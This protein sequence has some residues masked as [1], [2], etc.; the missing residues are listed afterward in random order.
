MPAL[1]RPDLRGSS[2]PAARPTS[3]PPVRRDC[4]G[5]GE[6][7]SGPRDEHPLPRRA[8]RS[9][10]GPPEA[11]RLHRRPAAGRRAGRGRRTRRRSGNP[12]DRDHRPARQ[13]GGGDRG[14]VHRWQ[15]LRALRRRRRDALVRGARARL[16]HPR[17]SR[18]ARPGGG[19][20]RPDR[21]RRGAAGPARRRAT[22]P[23]RRRGRG[24]GA[25]ER[26]SGARRRDRQGP[27]SRARAPGRGR[28]RGRGRSRRARRWRRWRSSTRPAT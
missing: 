11:H 18:A 19:D 13:P 1:R 6:R 4:G 24:A 14:A 15:R 3:A 2:S 17:G 16:R 25:G 20:L 26:R 7:G 12:G 28:L 23:A 10:T 21:R 5:A 22:P 9:A 8:S 27:R